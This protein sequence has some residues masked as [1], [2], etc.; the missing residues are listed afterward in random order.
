MDTTTLTSQEKFESF[1]DVIRVDVSY[2]GDSQS[3]SS[4]LDHSNSLLAVIPHF[5]FGVTL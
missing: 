3:S 1:G 4:D 2:E 5:F